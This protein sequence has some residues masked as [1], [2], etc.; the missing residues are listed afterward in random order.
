MRPANCYVFCLYAEKERSRVNVLDTSMWQFYVVPTERINRELGAQKSA[1]LSTIEAMAEP[2]GYAG[3][4]ERV[5]AVLSGADLYD[6]T[7]ASVSNEVQGFS[8]EAVQVAADDESST[9]EFHDTHYQD[10]QADYV[11]WLR[12]NPRAFV[13]NLKTKRWAVLH[14]SSCM[15]IAD[16][17]DPD[18][19]LTL[20]RK[21]CASSDAPLQA[22]AQERGV[23]WARCG[24]CL[25]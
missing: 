24:T 10:A 18:V 21:V 17:S 16:Y 23:K 3:L 13:L 19:S 22:W 2:V 14:E 5:E 11:Q 4:E 1:G 15:H 8:S 25:G 20:K 6:S 12:H 9:Q 7:G